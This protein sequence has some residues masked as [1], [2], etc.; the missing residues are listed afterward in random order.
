MS[1][2]KSEFEVLEEVA[3]TVRKVHRDVCEGDLI[4]AAWRVKHLAVFL[5]RAGIGAPLESMLKEESAS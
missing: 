2:K 1:E 3:V 5:D 4:V